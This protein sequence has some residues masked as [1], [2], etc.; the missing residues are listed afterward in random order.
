MTIGEIFSVL[1]FVGSMW[2]SYKVYRYCSKHHWNKGEGNG[3]FTNST[4]K[5]THFASKP[6]Q[7]STFTPK[8]PYFPPLFLH[9]YQPN[10]YKWKYIRKLI[11]LLIE[12]FIANLKTL[13][14]YRVNCIVLWKVLRCGKSLT[15]RWIQESIL[16]QPKEDGD[17]IL[18][19]FRII[20]KLWL[21]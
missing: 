15:Y 10:S 18:G 1:F 2:F 11:C 12:R 16:N 17:L 13:Q 7:N 19:Y 6:P 9:F 3:W 5:F 4:S 14:W 20:M 21:R 8:T